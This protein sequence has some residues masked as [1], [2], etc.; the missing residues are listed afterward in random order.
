MAK[1][2]LFDGAAVEALRQRAERFPE[3]REGARA[4]VDQA[5]RL[6]DEACYSEQEARGGITQHGAYLTQSHSFARSVCALSLAY[7]LTGREEFA[8]KAIEAMEHYYQLRGVVRAGLPHLEPSLA[9]GTGHRGLPRRIRFRLAGARERLTPEQQHSLAEAI[10]RLGIEP[11]WRD[12]L[13]PGRRIH[14][15][16]SMGHNWWAVCVGAAGVAALALEDTLPEA[17]QVAEAAAKGLRQWEAFPGSDT[18]NKPPNY[19]EH[20]GFWEG[21]GYSNYSLLHCFL[22]AEAWR[23]ARGETLGLDLSA[24]GG[25]FFLHTAYPT[26]EGLHTVDF[27]DHHFAHPAGAPVVAWLARE[28]QD[29]RLAWYWQQA[30]YK[31]DS[32]YTLLYW[33]P[34]LE[35]KAPEPQSLVFPAAGWAVR[36][37]SFEPDSTL[38]AVKCGSSWNHAH[39]DAGHFSLFHRGKRL[40]A[41]SGSC[42]YSHP[43]YREY[44]LHSQ[45]HNVLLVD[46]EGQPQE[47]VYRGTHLLGRLSPF[48]EGQMVAYL[49]A[50]CAGPYASTCQRYY[51]HFLW[52]GSELLVVDDVITW[53]AARPTW[54]LH[55]EGE[56]EELAEG[57]Y[58]LRAGEAACLVELAFPLAEV[59]QRLGHPPGEPDIDWPYWAF[60]SAEEATHHKLI[61]RIVPLEGTEPNAAAR[62]LSGEGWL[63]LEAESYRLFV[64]R[65]AD[66]TRVH[67]NSNN[68]FGGYETD[69]LLLLESPEELMMVDGSYLRRGG[70]S[71]YEGLAKG[72]RGG[73]RRGLTKT[74]LV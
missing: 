37:D 70:K 45:A 17:H 11:I 59:E 6:L 1:A 7:A 71:L 36:R 9:L 63:G 33:D 38:W 42:T 72:D 24:H 14:A 8:A 46:G 2:V 74:A 32:A 66:T 10:W 30:G 27:G 15:L 61:A 56:L 5:E 65:L 48:V 43:A 39:S 31:L 44:Y 3:V 62:M 69:A 41:D 29:A 47:D 4:L 35:P 26:G 51:R 22:F 20:G 57:R 53:Q 60:L 19:D 23:S 12:W 21:V 40:L 13:E 58:L 16:D 55:S 68:A 73:A 67:Q 50:E 64:N 49:R 28:T 18:Q 25:E 34:E 52:L 54:L